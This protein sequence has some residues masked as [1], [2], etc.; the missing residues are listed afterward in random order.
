MAALIYGLPL[1]DALR[2]GPV[3]SMRVVQF[4]GAQTGLLTKNEILTLLNKVQDPSSQKRFD[5]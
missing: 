2:W 4:F 3:E 5:S 1:E